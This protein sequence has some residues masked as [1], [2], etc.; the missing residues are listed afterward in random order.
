MLVVRPAGPAD[1]EALMELAVLS[2]RGFTSLPE[3]EAVLSERLALSQQSF[4]GAI[5]P[6][7]A[8]YTLMLTDGETGAVAGVAGVRAGVGIGRPHFSFRIVTLA[9]HSLAT[10]TRFDH[11]ALVLVNECA[12]WTEVGSLFVR[13]DRRSGGAGSLLARSRYMLIG[14][15]P[16][17]FSH[18]VMSELRG[19]FDEDG[20]SPFWEGVSYKFYRIPFEQADHM[21]TASDG[22]FIL[23]L[24]PRHPIYVELIDHGAA[25]AIGRV[26]RDGEPA[27]ALLEREGFERSGLVDI[28][29]GGP[30]MTC[31]RDSLAT[32]RGSRTLRLAIGHDVD[33]PQYLLSSV[34]I[35]KFRATQAAA[36]ID[37]GMVTVD[38]QTATALG[39]REGEAVRVNG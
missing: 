27:L 5:A 16:L 11:Q 22:Q 35:P 20:R 39:L 33:G 18:T 8:W 28:F 21:V 17:R 14:A 9:Q 13:A 30:T 32:V 19:W 36:A 31:A 3:D 25:E 6:A 2:G 7:E 26:H 12:G 24:A 1:L 23:D 34:A 37:D 29:D 15:D 4:T 38:P 10:K